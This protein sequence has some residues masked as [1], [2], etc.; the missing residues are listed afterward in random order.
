MV[1]NKQVLV[2]G[3]GI[4]GLTAAQELSRMGIS[5]FLI[6]KGL[7]IGGRSAHIACKATDKCMKCND[8]LVEDRLRE[9]SRAS[10]LD[11]SLSTEVENIEAEGDRF[12]IS[13]RS[14][15]KLIDPE[16][17]TDCHM[18]CRLF[19]FLHRFQSRKKLRVTPSSRSIKVKTITT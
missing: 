6:E 8:C 15:P 7:F 14:G 4:A 13:L 5:V 12:K 3:G 19:Q 1:N 17:R 16:K 11:T 10:G 2:I 9:I 18:G